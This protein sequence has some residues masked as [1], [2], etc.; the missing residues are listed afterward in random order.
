MHYGVVDADDNLVHYIDVPLP[1]PRLPH[2][3]AFTENYAILNDCPLFWDPEAARAGHVRGALPPGHA[4]PLRR[5]PAPRADRRHPLVRGRPDLRAALGQRVRG[6]RRDRARRL[7]P[8]DPEPPAGNGTL[9]QRMFRFL[10]NDQHAA[11][12]RTAGG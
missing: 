12:S 7:L 5:H 10:D 9:Y 11:R 2:D 1:G 6:G 8:A 4:D 3:M